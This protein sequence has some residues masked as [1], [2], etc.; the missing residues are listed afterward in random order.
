MICC[1]E[2]A[3]KSAALSI[4]LP[5]SDPIYDSPVSSP[6]L[7]QKCEFSIL[8]FDVQGRAEKTAVKLPYFLI[9]AIGQISI[10]PEIF[11]RYV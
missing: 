3:S 11:A 8:S 4:K 10:I 6:G 1:I 5:S 9:Y 7:S 2:P